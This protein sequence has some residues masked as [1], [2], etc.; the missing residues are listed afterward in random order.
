MGRNKGKVGLV[1]VE[2]SVYSEPRNVLSQQALIRSF[3]MRSLHNLYPIYLT[4]FYHAYA[5]FI[6]QHSGSLSMAHDVMLATTVVGE[7]KPDTE[8]VERSGHLLPTW[9][10]LGRRKT[11]G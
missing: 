2:G 9:S 11:R 8:E 5:S 3:L 1:F 7:H 10:R 6:S 4:Q